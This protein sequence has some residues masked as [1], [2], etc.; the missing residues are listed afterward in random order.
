MIIA[1]N[2]KLEKKGEKSRK[3]EEVG[4]GGEM[5]LGE[6]EEG[7]GGASNFTRNNIIP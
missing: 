6:K 1:Y 7:E 2:Y 3:K 5:G 4:G